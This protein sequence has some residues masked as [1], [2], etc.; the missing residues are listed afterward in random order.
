MIFVRNF[1]QILLINL[2]FQIGLKPDRSFVSPI[3]H[4]ISSDQI[5]AELESNREGVKPII[6]T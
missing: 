5:F 1:I 4:P 2:F 6:Y 3:V